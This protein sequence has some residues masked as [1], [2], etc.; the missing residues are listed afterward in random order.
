MKT[1]FETGVFIKRINRF[2]V[3]FINN[4]EKKSL[5][6]LPNPGRLWELLIP[7]RKIYVQKKYGKLPYLLWAVERENLHICLHTHYFNNI[8]E[9]FLKSKIIPSLKNFNIAGR[10]V[11][12]G[13]SRIDFLLEN[14]KGNKIPLEVKSCTLFE[15][16]FAMFPDAPSVRGKRHIETIAKHSGIILLII[17]NPNVKYF[18]PDFHTD[19][20][21]AQTLYNYKNKITIIPITIKWS[22]SIKAKFVKEIDIPWHIFEEEG[23]NKGAYLI[24]GI[25]E[26]NITFWN[27]KLKK[28]YYIYVGSSMN[29]LQSRINRHLRKSKKFRWHIDYLIPHLKNMK[30]IPIRSSERLECSIAKDIEKISLLPLEKFGSTDCKCRSHLFYFKNNPFADENFIKIILKYRIKRLEKFIC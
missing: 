25:L 23:Q 12:F 2:T 14:S 26:K 9:S 20:D 30:A 21:F 11:K 27:K 28:G 24:V 29:S 6:Y 4:E 19:I 1:I 22:K 7:K 18:L 16:K 13:N 17:S 8:A 3:E 10:E 15:G 5:A